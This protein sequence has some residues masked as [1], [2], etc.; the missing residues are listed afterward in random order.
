MYKHLLFVFSFLLVTHT[1]LA[2]VSLTGTSYTETF[3]GL[4]SGLPTGWSSY[5][6]ATGTSLGTVTSF[7][8]TTVS[9]ATSTGNFR[10]AA[11]ADGLTGTSSTASQGSSTDR[12]L[13][14]R[15]TGSFGDPGAAFAVQLANTS[16]LQS[17]KLSL[18][19][20][21]LDATS[22][23]VTT[24]SV[25]YGLG[26]S[27]T[28][29]NTVVTQPIGGT[30]I[31][32]S[33][34]T[35]TYDF[36]SALDNQSQAVWIRIVALAS[37]SGSGNRATTGLDDFSLTYTSLTNNPT[38]GVLP[39]TLSG[40][41]Y[42]AGNGPS[43]PTT[44]TV[45]G[46]NLTPTTPVTVTPPSS[47]EI[48]TDGT[49]YVTSPV[50]LTPTAGGTLSQSIYARIVAG[51]S[52]NSYSGNVTVGSTEVTGSKT[53]A[54]SGTVYPAGSVGPC[55]TS[56]VISAVRT[57][58]DN[59][60]FTVTGRV[61]SNIGT[62]IYIQDAT[63]GILLY[64]GTGTTVDV[65][66]VSIGDEVQVTGLLSTY[67]TDREMKNFT[68][69]FVKTTADNVTPATTIVTT[70]NLCD[71]V[72]RGE[73]VTLQA[74][75]IVSPTGTTFAGNTNYTLSDG[76][77]LRIQNGTDLVGATRPTGAVDITGV[78]SLFNGVCQLLP[79]STADVPNSTPNVASCP[80]VGT[81]GTAISTDNTLDIAWWN[82][83]WFGNTGFGPTNEAQQQAN[84]EQQ[85]Q[86]MNED[87]YC[88]E[89][90]CDLTKLDAQIAIL[91][92]NTG[93]TYAR[94]C[95]DVSGRKPPIYYSHWFDDPEV[96]GDATTYAQKVCF[97]YNTAIVTNVS[98]SQ[99]LTAAPGGSDWA[100]N[101]FPLMMSCDVTI[102][103]IKKS[104]KLVGLHAK[105]GS[106]VSSYTRRQ[107]DYAALKS[108]LDSNY[109]TDN[110]LIMGDY[111]DDA[112]Q[113][114]Y[115]PDNT[116]YPVSSFNNFVTSPDYTVIT[117]QLS[118]CNIASTAAYP[119]IID[120]LT[121]SN[122]ISTN[123]TI[124]ASGIQYI[125][126]SVKV[127]RPITGGTTTSDHFPVTARFQF[128]NPAP[129]KL[130]SFTGQSK[131]NAIAL[132][133]VTASEEKN[134]G[135]DI[136]KSTSATSL[137]KVGF[138]AGHG[139][140]A[141]Q[142]VYE[143]PDTD[144]QAGQLYYYQLKQR[145]I[146]GNTTLS[147]IIAVRASQIDDSAPVVYPNPSN[148]NF[149]LKLKDAQNTAVKLYNLTGLEMPASS[150]SK[151]VGSDT[152]SISPKVSLP[153]GMYYL[154]TQSVDGSYKKTIKIA[155]F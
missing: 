2:Q 112:D 152:I 24:W 42:I 34:N 105:S 27:P 138:L 127:I 92:A 1:L 37:S 115:S 60:T 51:L 77:I 16:G 103:G 75:S 135:F 73:L 68:T 86:S 87:I 100:S 123:G 79:R 96:P 59:T 69:C 43:A 67:N 41:T 134:E 54:L 142:S 143:F 38:I 90:V 104:L 25:Q 125:T 130:L 120:H 13:A 29:F 94:T 22:P 149:T 33:N 97:V 91:S 4:S 81:G 93:K 109:P 66:E 131:E 126:N 99:L 21:S 55:G 50:S 122:E 63:G 116:T 132:N 76:T 28:T 153:A 113:S 147:N 17:V 98:A 117:K 118:T 58:A 139:T 137:E 84:V 148:G 65:P 129:V 32:F 74:V 107:A 31:G 95:G 70:A 56:T 47:F 46:S 136:L 5:T 83:E 88:L 45:T 102:T 133:W 14:V 82:I 141:S 12:A 30:V 155:I 111:N 26:S 110:V 62:N 57:A 11:S 35:V 10:N 145:D 3:D 49:T 48:S 80:E 72:H 119:D 19:L 61:I 151:T 9:W 44:F 144:V 39:T 154:Q 128:S 7:A 121:V 150:W 18:K 89:E 36:G 114:I 85:L 106:D 8:N 40:M 101:R 23:R 20:Q 64:T 140:T 124:P 108:Y 71:P 6:G 53:I 52:A 146:G 15:Q 78:V